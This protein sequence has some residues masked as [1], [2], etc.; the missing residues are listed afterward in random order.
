MHEVPFN[1][2]GYLG[3]LGKLLSDLDVFY[4]E[5]TNILSGDFCENLIH[6]F[7]SISFTSKGLRQDGEGQN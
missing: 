7:H 4:L 6:F 2:I 3:D 1:N 5:K